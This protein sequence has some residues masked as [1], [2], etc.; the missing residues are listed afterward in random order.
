MA[1]HDGI[2]QLT[3]ITDNLL[4]RERAK[5]I[6]L[7]VCGVR[8]V[9]NELLV[10]TPDV[11]DEELNR[12]LATALA[13]DPATSDCNMQAAAA[14]G[15]VIVTGV[16]QSW[17]EQQLVLRVLRGGSVRRPETDALTIRW[18]EM[19][20]S[21]EEI[22][23]QIRELLDWDVRVHSPL[24]EIR[25][26]DRVVHLA[27]TVGPAAEKAQVVTTAYQAGATHVDARDLLVTYW[28]FL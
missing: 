8:G 17:A 3:G 28:A 24:V 13:D 7:A 9:V 19:Q 23:T 21:D 27:G 11:P 5:E 1:T 26:E 20:N 10:S 18:G 14:E 12:H 15:V 4:A 6:A 25:T 22:T 16:V 2:V